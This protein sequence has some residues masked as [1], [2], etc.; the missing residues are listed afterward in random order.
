MIVKPTVNELLNYAENRFAL[1]IATS[2]RARQIAKQTTRQ[3]KGN[4]ISPVTLAANEIAE[5]KIEIYRNNEER[6]K[7]KE[8][9]EQLPQEPIEEL[10]KEVENH[11]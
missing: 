6:P 3:T 5:G 11:E 10:I 2:K 9:T 7:V 1:V 8:W 4:K